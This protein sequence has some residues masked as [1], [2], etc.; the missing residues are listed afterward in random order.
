MRLNNS[1]LGQIGDLR[2]ILMRLS[3]LEASSASP[4]TPRTYPSTSARH[5]VA[6]ALATP[7]TAS[8]D[9]SEE[10]RK[11][12]AMR[13]VARQELQK[14][15]RDLAQW[16]G[17][18]GIHL[19]Q[20]IDAS[21]RPMTSGGPVPGGSVAAIGK[22]RCLS[23]DQPVAT[24]PGPESAEHIAQ[25]G[26]F[27]TAAGG[28]S[29][30]VSGAIPSISS[31]PVTEASANAVRPQSPQANLR[32]ATI[33]QFDGITVQEM[34]ADA[35]TIPAT[36]SRLV[37]HR[38]HPVTLMSAVDNRLYKGRTDDEV[39]F[40]PNATGRK[41]SAQPNRFVAVSYESSAGIPARHQRSAGDAS[42]VQTASP[43][44]RPFTAAASS[45]M[46]PTANAGETPLRAQPPPT[47][48]MPPT[49]RKAEGPQLHLSSQ[50]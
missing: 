6:S 38:G 11:R 30:H 49:A 26:S 18:V 35:A 5:L 25:M 34:R 21:E 4:I 8:S 40:V 39:S 46:S 15:E 28:H 16:L 32:S 44:A 50:N 12:H 36:P 31:S 19:P 10:K 22:I 29:V 7:P 17:T 37:V 24:L 42:F 14:F 13:Q 2:S 3:N 20:L 9:E 45:M 1:D 27:Y 33:T 43:R 48:P 41:V 47:S 23:C